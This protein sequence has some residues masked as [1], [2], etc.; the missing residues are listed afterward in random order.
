MRRIHSSTGILCMVLTLF[1]TSIEANTT[2]SIWYGSNQSFAVLGQP[3]RQVNILG[4]VSDP[5]GVSSLSYSLNGGATLP[6]SIGPKPS[7][8]KRLVGVG[9]FNVE[10][11][12]ADMINGQNTVLLTATNGA[13]VQ[14]T[15]SVTVN[16]DKNSVWPIPYSIDWST[17]ANIQ[18]AVQIVDGLWQKSGDVLRILEP[19]YDRAIAF[20]DRNWKNYEVTATV[21]AHSIDP[22]CVNDIND[23]RGNPAVSVLVR[24][25]GHYDWDNGTVQPTIGYFPIGAIGMYK[26]SRGDLTRGKLVLEGGEFQVLAEDGSHDLVF[27]VPHIFKVRAETI[28]GVGHFYSFKMWQE[29]TAEPEDWHLVGQEPLT[30][31]SLSNG[32]VL[33]AAHNVVAS[34]GNVSVVPLTAVTAPVA[35]DDY[36]AAT[37][38]QNTP[39]NTINVLANDT[40]VDNATISAFDAQSVNGGQLSSNNDGTFLYS[41]RTDFIGSDSFTYTL[42]DKDGESSSATVN[43]MVVSGSNPSGLISDNFD[44]LSLDDSVWSLYDPVGSATIS[45]AGGQLSFSVPSGVENSVWNNGVRAPSVMQAVNDADFDVIAKFDSQLIGRY[46]GQGILVEQD[47]NNVIRFDFYQ[48]DTGSTLRIFTGIIDNGN[49]SQQ[50][51]TVITN[52]TPQYLRVTRTGDE[53]VE[54]YSYDGINWSI[55]TRFIHNI[56]V[57]KVGLFAN[58][59][60]VNAPAYTVLVDEFVVIGEVQNLTPV[61]VDDPEAATTLEDTPVTTVNVLLNDTVVDNA[62]INTYDLVSNK[63]GNVTYNGDGTFLYSPAF[64]FHGQDYFSYTLTDENGESSSAIVTINVI[65]VND[66]YPIAVDDP[67]AAKTK[68]GVPVRTKN[69]LANDTLVDSAYISDFDR[70]TEHGGIISEGDNGTFVYTPQRDFLGTDSF[71]YTLTDED[72]E[73]ATATVSIYVW[74]DNRKK[75]HYKWSWLCLWPG[76]DD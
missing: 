36:D 71:T 62:V 38:L 74:K 58:N 34:F 56:S 45:Q 49:P 17:T 21:T 24:W 6:L 14:S 37:T 42:T 39:V 76:D 67:D 63:R 57:N 16:V 35:V 18:N 51:K 75:C 68:Q 64:D 44:G 32:S 52:A 7:N 12:Y 70:I 50:V 43:V 46:Q 47:E 22:R 65:A 61:A 27:G 4:N 41:P 40:L 73:S 23:C 1:A 60:D 19:G 53:W 33:M 29:G 54:S 72:Q 55:A 28:D 2:F 3:Q 11:L 15:E 13:G 10:L 69:V 31:A 8:P 66:G 9:D 25:Q 5:A 59:F 26:Y 48:N 20:G 30:S